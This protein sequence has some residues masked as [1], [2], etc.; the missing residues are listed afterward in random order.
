[1]ATFRDMTSKPFWMLSPLSREECVNRLREAI[2]LPGEGRFWKH[3]RFRGIAD[4]SRLQIRLSVDSGDGY[5]SPL[6]GTF[7]DCDGKTLIKCNSLVNIIVILWL[8]CL[9]FI[10]I[11]IMIYSERYNYLNYSSILFS[12]MLVLVF[13]ILAPP[14][15]VFGQLAT[16]RKLTDFLGTTIQARKVERHDLDVLDASAHGLISPT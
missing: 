4:N 15:Y 9:A 3:K 13:V 5:T 7:V 1:M 12:G 8:Y 6:D 16:Q 2:D 11:L 14:A 10:P